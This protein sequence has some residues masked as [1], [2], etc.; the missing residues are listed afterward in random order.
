MNEE[1]RQVG[2]EEECLDGCQ[3]C[4]FVRVCVFNNRRTYPR[5][6]LVEFFILLK[7]PSPEELAPPTHNTKPYRGRYTNYQ[8]IKISLLFSDGRCSI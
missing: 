4:A 7:V 3:P 6:G 5:V 1:T 2:K 8:C